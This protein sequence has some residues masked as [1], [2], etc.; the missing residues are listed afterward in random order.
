[1]FTVYGLGQGMIFN[2]N[3]FNIFEKIRIPDHAC[4]SGH[5]FAI[6]FHPGLKYSRGRPHPA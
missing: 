4:G 1:M 3:I 6:I 2:L 5:Q